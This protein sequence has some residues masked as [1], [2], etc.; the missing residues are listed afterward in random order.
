MK[1]VEHDNFYRQLGMLVPFAEL[2]AC[3]MAIELAKE[4]GD[5]SRLILEIDNADVIDVQ[6]FCAFVKKIMLVRMVQEIE[7]PWQINIWSC[8]ISRVC[9]FDLRNSV[10]SS[11]Y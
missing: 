2:I 9:T 8:S 6:L 11:T 10:I 1:S 7:D 5:V 3:K 4:G